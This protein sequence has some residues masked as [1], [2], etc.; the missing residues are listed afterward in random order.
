M[1]LS[2]Q[3]DGSDADKLFSHAVEA[4]KLQVERTAASIPCPEH[5]KIASNLRWTGD[6]SLEF[7]ACCEAHKAA[8]VE[9]LQ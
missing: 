4:G 8:I 6:D 3:F 1:A 2:F 5:G 9:G 7:D